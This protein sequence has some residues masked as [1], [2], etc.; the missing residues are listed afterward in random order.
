M[1]RKVSI[2][3]IAMIAILLPYIGMAIMYHWY[4]NKMEQYERASFIIVDK[5]KMN[6][7]VYDRN[8]DEVES[9]PIGCGQN[10]GNKIEEGDNRTPEGIFRISDIQDSSNWKHDFGDGKGEVKGAYGN[11]FL[12]LSAD[13][14]KGIGIHGTH[15]PKSVGTRCTEG[16][17]R[18]SN[19]DIVRLHD[20]AYRGLT[21]IILPSDNDVKA[22][23]SQTN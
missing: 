12:R 19:D 8:G 20:I 3:I 4:E 13:P 2:G 5:G 7:S 16:C 18:L 10:Y 15:L 11:Y 22:N 17:I 6:L 23:Q 14:H 21:V 9:F 1:N